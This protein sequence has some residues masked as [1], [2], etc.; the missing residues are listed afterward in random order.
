PKRRG[1]ARGPLPPAPSPLR[2][3]GRGEGFVR[4]PLD[5]RLAQSQDSRKGFGQTRPNVLV[6]DPQDSEAVSRQ[7]PISLGVRLPL[8]LVNQTINFHNASRS[9]AVEINDKAIDTLLPPKVK[10]RQAVGSEVL[11]KGLLLRGHLAAELLGRLDLHLFNPLTDDDVR[12]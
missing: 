11:P 1:G 2:G 8:L 5:L 12:D 6:C 4:P 9:M 10:A 7:D 3:G